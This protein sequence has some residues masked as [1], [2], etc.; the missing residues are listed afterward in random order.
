LAAT[1]LLPREGWELLIA[2]S[3]EEQFVRHV[4][5]LPRH[6]NV[7]LVGKVEPTSFLSDLDTLIV[8][9]QWHEA[10]GL[11]VPEAFSHGVPVLAARRAGLSQLVREGETGFLFDPDDSME[12]AELLARV[13]GDPAAL[14][15][16]RKSCLEQA[17]IFDVDEVVGRYVR[18]YEAVRGTRGRVGGAMSSRG[19][20]RARTRPSINGGQ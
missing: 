2:G 14:K 12:L 17:K 11:V 3:G 16:L 13:I 5:Q 4:S 7:R 1:V 9:S 8:P 18:S 6:P 19:T 10:A 15:K 20:R